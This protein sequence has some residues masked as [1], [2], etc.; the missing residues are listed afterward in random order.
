MPS[1]NNLPPRLS[2]MSIWHGACCNRSK[3]MLRK[4]SLTAHSGMEGNQ[5]QRTFCQK[6]LLGDQQW[7]HVPAYHRTVRQCG[8]SFPAELSVVAQRQILVRYQALPWPPCNDQ[9]APMRNP[10]QGSQDLLKMP[11]VPWM[12]ARAGV[13]CALAGPGAPVVRLPGGPHRGA[14]GERRARPVRRL[15]VR[16]SCA[17]SALLLKAALC[18]HHMPC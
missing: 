8:D 7:S 16:P 1:L 15:Q 13:L 6:A 5:R 12:G 10:V 2:D 18:G 4:Q 3:E 9:T 11:E 17:F 14:G